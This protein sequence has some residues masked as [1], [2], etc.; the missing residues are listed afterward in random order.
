MFSRTPNLIVSDSAR[1]L[2]AYNSKVLQRY[3]KYSFRGFHWP[4]D[5]DNQPTNTCLNNALHR[6]CH[7][8]TVHCKWLSAQHRQRYSDATPAPASQLTL[9]QTSCLAVP[10]QSSH[11]DFNPSGFTRCPSMNVHVHPVFIRMQPAR[12]TGTVDPPASIA[13]LYTAETLIRSTA[14][15]IETSEAAIATGNST[16]LSPSRRSPAMRVSDRMHAWTPEARIHVH[17]SRTR[18]CARTESGRHGRASIGRS[19]PFP[20]TTTKARFGP[21]WSK[22]YGDGVQRARW[23]WWGGWRCCA[24][25]YIT[26]D[27]AADSLASCSLLLMARNL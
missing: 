22:P 19:A 3:R 18:C 7:L 17:R 9:Q 14:D 24:V 10:S 2:D 21:V 26:D 12:L 6:L 27:A 23:A 15:R 11:S 4:T 8:C 25:S 20:W 1:S 13:M 5:R 16:T